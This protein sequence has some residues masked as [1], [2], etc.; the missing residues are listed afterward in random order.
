M[1]SCQHSA[2]ARPA[3][4]RSLAATSGRAGAPPAPTIVS[5]RIVCVYGVWVELN[6]D[7]ATTLLPNSEAPEHEAAPMVEAPN[8]A[9][10][11]TW[12][13]AFVAPM[14]QPAA[15]VPESHEFAVVVSSQR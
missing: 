10:S 7:G 5:A 3:S 9:C 15:P 6:S 8:T 14:T 11:L 2:R 13:A 1:V 4:M 12:S